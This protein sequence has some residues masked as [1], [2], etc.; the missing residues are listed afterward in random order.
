MNSGMVTAAAPVNQAQQT[1]TVTT[2]PNTSTEVLNSQP[3]SVTATP[4]NTVSQEV[5]DYNNIYNVEA[6][7]D[8]EKT[9]FFDVFSTNEN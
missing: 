5:A 6:N 2:T 9:Q 4:V 1:E 3:V 7:N 8:L